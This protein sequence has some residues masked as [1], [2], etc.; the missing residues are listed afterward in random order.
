MDRARLLAFHAAGRAAWPE[1]NV[2][3][4]RLER[5][6][7]ERA[8]ESPLEA[9]QAK[10]V[11]LAC[12]CADGDAA[13]IVAFD[14]RYLQAIRSPLGRI[15][16]DEA[17]LDELRQ[18]LRRKLFVPEPGERARILDYAGRGELGGWLHVAAVR[19]AL[20]LVQQARV[21]GARGEL[22]AED[23][24]L[25]DP[26]TQDPELAY[27]KQVYR[28]A[29]RRAFRTALPALTD[30]EQNL[31]RQH[32]LDGLS[33]IELGRLLDVHRVTASRWLDEA[34][35]ALLERVRAEFMREARI[36]RSECDSFF[37][38]VQ[39]QLDVTFRGLLR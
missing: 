28:E 15:V 2:S 30:R 8:Q 32:Y 4:A 17:T 13:A 11:Y 35:S 7:A 10:D 18:Q 19:T 23:D 9:L 38:L 16:L 31:L 21:S 39:S 22:L 27:I 29:F 24:H 1:L 12:A 5:F 37:R 34:K 20:N 25:I 6:V 26:T 3:P 33:I 36:P 14:V